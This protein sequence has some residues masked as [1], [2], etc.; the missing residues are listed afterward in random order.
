MKD[1]P[2]YCAMM[3][4]IFSLVSCFGNVILLILRVLER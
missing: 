1:D 2:A 3:A 4:M